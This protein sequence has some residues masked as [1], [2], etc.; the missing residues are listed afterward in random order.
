[1]TVFIGLSFA[2]NAA[3]TV[4]VNI[5]RVTVTMARSYNFNSAANSVYV[6]VEFN[7]TMSADEVADYIEESNAFLFDHYGE[8]VVEMSGVSDDFG[9]IYLDIKPNTGIKRVL[10]ITSTGSSSVVERNDYYPMGMRTATGNSYPQLTTNLYKYNGKEVQTVGGLG[11]T[12]YG[13][14]MYDD[15]TGRWFVPDPLAEKYSSMS[16]YIYCGG[17]PV[18]YIDWNGMEWKDDKDKEIAESLI[19]Q[20]NKRDYLLSKQEAKINARIKRI[21]DNVSLS[22]DKKDNQILKEQFKLENVKIQRSLLSTLNDGLNQLENSSTIY[23]FNT[24]A[25]GTTATLS[26]NID[27]TIV[28]NNYGTTGNRAHEVTHAIQYHFGK[29]SFNP[30]GSNNVLMLNPYKLEIQAYRIEY[31]ITNGLIPIS[32]SKTPKNVFGITLQWLLGLKD[33]NTGNYIYRPENYKRK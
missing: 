23:T 10:L 19:Q 12:D 3:D 16:P 2:A 30:V 5:P 15:F 4:R 6:P 28:I 25:Q 14:R 33:P 21:E 20:A 22:S 29:I 18:M 27:G 26:S 8:D 13:A 11:F 9:T 32:D 31:S 17:N 24:V 1:M 7:S